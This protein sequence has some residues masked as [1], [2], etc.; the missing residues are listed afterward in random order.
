VKLGETIGV[1]AVLGFY[2]LGTLGFPLTCFFNPPVVS[3]DRV[4]V[5]GGRGGRDA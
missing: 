5:R 3:R 4:A 1:G 2:E